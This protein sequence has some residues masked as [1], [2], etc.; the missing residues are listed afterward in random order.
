MAVQMNFAEEEEQ[1]PWT[2]SLEKKNYEPI[3]VLPQ[4]CRTVPVPR[5]RTLARVFPRSSSSGSFL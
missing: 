2:K 4:R 5:N 1:R 3:Y